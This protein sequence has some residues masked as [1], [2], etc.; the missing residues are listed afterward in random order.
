MLVTS[1]LKR[2]RSM[3]RGRPEKRDL[4][5]TTTTTPKTEEAE[6]ATEETEAAM[7]HPREASMI[8]LNVLELP[9]TKKEGTALEVASI[10]LIDLTTTI[11][12]GEALTM[13][14]REIAV[15]RGHPSTSSIL[16]TE[17]AVVLV[18]ALMMTQPQT[19][20]TMLPSLILMHLHLALG[21]TMHPSGAPEVTMVIEAEIEASE[22]REAVATVE[23]MAGEIMAVAKA[24]LDIMEVMM[25]LVAAQSLEACPE[26]A[27]ACLSV[28]AL[29][30]ASVVLRTDPTRATMTATEEAIERT[31]RPLSLARK[32]ATEAAGVAAKSLE[33]VPEAASTESAAASRAMREKMLEAVMMASPHS[34]EAEAASTI[35][36]TIKRPDSEAVIEA[37]VAVTQ[38]A[39]IVVASVGS[40]E[41]TRRAAEAAIAVSAEVTPTAAI[42]VASTTEV[43]WIRQRRRVQQR[44]LPWRHRRRQQRRLQQ[45][46]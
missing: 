42:V 34:E 5:A 27:L 22:A 41:V 10:T 3:M 12:V 45:R 36:A 14:K 20:D 4:I 26:A 2:R 28:A 18:L 25:S 21:I 29:E 31:R 19:S 24:V 40:A 37:T 15:K 39:A 8:D 43:P 13:T 16:G 7:M 30:A 17:V 38:R 32:V 9:L 35:E 6:V 33:A 23:S 1:L 44:R 46:R 11:E